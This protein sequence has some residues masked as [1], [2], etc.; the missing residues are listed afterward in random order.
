MPADRPTIS[1][2]LVRDYAE[3]RT[4]WREIRAL[5]GIED[6]N[7]MLTRLGDEGL[8]LPRASRDRP[9]RAKLWLAE[10]L[11]ARSAAASA[12]LTKTDR[13]GF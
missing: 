11:A 8:R 4:S 6:F 13:V 12:M 9:S 1:A 3:G 5:T 7:I 10:I 2:D